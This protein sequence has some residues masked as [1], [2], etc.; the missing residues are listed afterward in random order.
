MEKTA[1]EMGFEDGFQK[2]AG[3]YSRSKE[4]L[5]GSALDKMK[6]Q[7]AKFSKI[8]PL[9]G[10]AEEIKK[11]MGPERFKVWL[12]RSAAAGGAGLAGY[13]G[14]RALAGNNKEKRQ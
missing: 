4:L 2:S 13:G 6:E 1:F 12:S 9:Q 3:I 7:A 14:Y 10:K 8:K 11:A 5:S